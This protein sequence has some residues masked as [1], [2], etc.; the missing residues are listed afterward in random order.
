[1]QKFLSMGLFGLMQ[2]VGSRKPDAKRFQ[3]HASSFTL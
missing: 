3:L 1:M 2:E